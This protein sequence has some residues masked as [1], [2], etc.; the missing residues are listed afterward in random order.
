MT[1]A[2]GAPLFLRRLSTDEFQPPPYTTA[3][4]RVLDCT[5][6]TLE[7][8]GHR[9]E[10]SPSALVE[11]RL[12]TAAGLRALNEEWGAEFFE[13]PADAAIDA[14]V[15]RE[16]FRKREPVID[17]QTHFMG[18]RAHKALPYEFLAGMY[19]SLMPDWWT[20]MDDLVRWDLAAYI[21]NVFLETETAVAVLTS[22]PGISEDGSRMLFNDEMAA[23]R[24]LFERFAGTGRILNH[25]VVHADVDAEV[26]AMAFW[27]D[28]YDPVGWKVYTPGRRDP[29]TGWTSGWMLDDEQYGFRFL[30]RARDLGVTLICA[31]KG[32]SQLVDNGSP[33]DVGPAAA[34]FPDLSLVV[35]HSGY[36][37]PMDGAPPEG[38]YEDASA[39]VGVNRLITSLKTAGVGRGSNVYAELGSTWFSLIRRPVEAAHVLGKL[40]HHVGED[41]VIWGTDSIWYGAAQPILDALRVFQIP[42]EMCERYGYAKLTPEI[43]DKITTFNAA[44]VYNID[45]DNVRA[46]IE[47]DEL[48]WAK[49]LLQD[50]KGNGF[51]ALR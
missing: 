7:M 45:L 20:E 47:T 24:A 39:D 15:A 44:G 40:V 22:G 1:R 27:R 50:L 43:K 4:L 41:N 6:A 11:T 33:R 10:Q 17:V 18:P 26:E 23:T 49:A 48:A 2:I 28:E 38:P 25:A 35:Y 21:N 14:D 42:D 31:H 30:E 37:L 12:G 9:L 13:V 16:I 34:A 8:T 46:R 51:S 3:D 36:E 32:I 29:R 19:R 5:R